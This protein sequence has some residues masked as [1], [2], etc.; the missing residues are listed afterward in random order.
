MDTVTELIDA[1]LADTAHHSL[2]DAD[3][4]HNLLLDIRLAIVPVP[5]AA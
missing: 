2:I 5:V 4:V 1:F 3:R